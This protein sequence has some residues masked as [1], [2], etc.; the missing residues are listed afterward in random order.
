MPPTFVIFNALISACISLFGAIGNILI[1]IAFIK[2]K[3]LQT[4][5]NVFL[6][7]VAIVDFTKAVFILSVKAYT[8]LADE[9][10]VASYYCPFSGFISCITFVHSAMLLAAIAVVRYVKIVK[11]RS[12]ETMFTRKRMVYYCV[13]LAASTTILAILP[14]VGVGEY[15]YSDYHGVCFT[16]WESKNAVFR[17]LFYVY[18]MGLCFPVIIFCYAYIFLSLRKHKQRILDNARLARKRSAQKAASLK[19]ALVQKK[20]EGSYRIMKSS[21]NLP[22]VTEPGKEQ[23]SANDEK[24]SLEWNVKL[25][26]GKS[27]K[28]PG[29]NDGNNHDD[30]LTDNNSK[31][32]DENAKQPEPA[33]QTGRTDNETKESSNQLTVKDTPTENGRPKSRKITFPALVTKKE[34]E[35]GS[36]GGRK[37][38]LSS[39]VI[40][41][42]IRI[43]KVMFTV[44]IAFC[45]CWLPA[46]F[47]NVLL[48]TNAVHISPTGRYVVITLVDMKVLLNPL[49]YGIW[50]KQFRRA[51][52]SIFVNVI[53]DVSSAR[54]PNSR[55]SQSQSNAAD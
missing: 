6:F 37:A 26:V 39:R 3:S 13:G 12:F 11:T 4:V 53:A 19:A 48:L 43:T 18:I 8:E 46:F 23:N 7:Q 40:N 45:V 49:I 50:N 51:L 41:K 25:E 44:V 5:N 31:S 35:T 10:Y 28:V 17:S 30:D 33:K 20:K 36:N 2:T 32:L 52:K 15:A 1:I 24:K 54:E 22:V 55:T 38:K 47:A 16:N 21:S 29:D 27:E 34:K 14:L 42:E 9:H